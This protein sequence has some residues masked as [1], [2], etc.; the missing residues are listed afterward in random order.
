[1]DIKLLPKSVVFQ[2][3][4]RTWMIDMHVSKHVH[5]CKLREL[6]VH[7]YFGFFYECL[8]LVYEKCFCVGQVIYAL[9]RA[10]KNKQHHNDSA[11][12]LSLFLMNVLFAYTRWRSED[13]VALLFARM[14]HWN[15]EVTA[16]VHPSSVAQLDHHHS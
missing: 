6:T 10:C 4:G 2:N 1:M 12:K 9:V 7:A 15:I 5:G 16:E 3:I 8:P 13:S 14:F 11:H